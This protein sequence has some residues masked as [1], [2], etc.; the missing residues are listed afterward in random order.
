MNRYH[1]G[2]EISCDVDLE[3]FKIYGP[4]IYLFFSFLKNVTVIFF[5]MSIVQLIPIIYNYIAGNGL[6]TLTISLNY[7]FARTTIA[8]FSA[9]TS[10]SPSQ[11]KLINVVSDMFCILIFIV[12]YFFWLNRGNQLTEEVRKQVKLKSYTVVEVVDPPTKATQQD[13]RNFMSQF[14]KIV[15]IAPVKDYDESINLSKTIY[16]LEVEVKEL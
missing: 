5:L 10:T 3:Y 14:G 15:E 9:S 6:S 16:D 11:D 8:A 12:F 1:K 7:Y 13:V 4:G 2:Q